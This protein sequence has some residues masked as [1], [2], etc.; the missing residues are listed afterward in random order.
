MVLK[1]LCRYGGNCYRKNLQYLWD[2]SYLNDLLELDEEVNNFKRKRV[3]DVIDLEENEMK[4]IK[5]VDLLKDNDF[6]EV[7]ESFNESSCDV[8]EE[9]E[10][11]L[12]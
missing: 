6:E 8:K 1:K 10:I 7:L 11:D 2:Y 5:G 3:N 9:E 12:D 4:K